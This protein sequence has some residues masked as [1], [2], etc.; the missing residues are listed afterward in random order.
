[1]L[2]MQHQFR[3]CFKKCKLLCETV[4]RD[5]QFLPFCY[6]FPSALI[7]SCIVLIFRFL[8]SPTHYF[9][10]LNHL[11]RSAGH[12]GHEQPEALRAS[13]W[14]ESLRPVPLLPVPAGL[15]ERRRAAAERPGGA[16]RPARSLQH[17]RRPG[18]IP[19]WTDSGLTHSFHYIQK[20]R[21]YF[22]R[23]NKKYC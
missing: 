7:V 10:C 14:D 2:K 4:D 13:G 5:F 9:L 12:P 18:W 11:C 15:R 21:I 20:L 3:L 6:Y 8:F 23:K 22:V 16:Q 1:M 17:H 19:Q